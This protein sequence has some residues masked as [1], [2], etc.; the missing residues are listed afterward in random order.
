M[1]KQKVDFQ[2]YEDLYRLQYQFIYRYIRRMLKGDTYTAE[3]LT[4]E[5]FLVAFQKWESDVVGHPNV[6]GYLIR[7]AQNKLKKWYESN[8]RAY[9]DETEVINFLDES[10]LQYK[11]M[12]EYEK[13]EFYATLE[14]YLSVEEMK[15]LRYYYEYD[16]SS[17]E[18]AQIMKVSDHC[19]R[20]RMTRM[21]SKLRKYLGGIFVMMLCTICLF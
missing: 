2:C 19:F 12:T 11:D 1:Q 14:K 18:M 3:D 20:M 15:L 7:I 17:Y 5:V 10:A 21:R 8:S 9:V 4:Q 13:A 16:Y 6:P